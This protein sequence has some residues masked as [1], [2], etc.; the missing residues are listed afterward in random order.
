MLKYID[1]H[2]TDSR[3]WD[4]M[5][6]TFSSGELLPLW[7]ADMDFETMPAVKDALKDFVDAAPFGYYYPREEYFEAIMDWEETHHGHKIDRNSICFAPS[8]VAAFNWILLMA[9]RPGDSVILLTPIYGP[10]KKAIVNNDRKFVEC[11]LI[12][13]GDTYEIDFD[14]FEAK[15]KNNN[16][17]LFILCS[18]HNPVGR[19]WR[20]AELVKLMEICRRYNVLVISDE[21][22]HDFCFGIHKHTPT[23]CC[24]NYKNFVITLTSASKTFN[25]AGCKN[26]IVIIED[27]KLRAMY[28]DFTTRIAISDGSSFGYVAVEAAYKNGA[29][30]LGDVKDVIW[31][32]YN[33]VKDAFAESLPKVV[34]GKLEGTYLLWIDFSAYFESEES[35]KYFME[36]VCGLAF[37]YGS[38]FGTGYDCF[39]RM[40]LA[41]SRENV[42]MATAQIIAELQ[43]IGL[44]GYQDNAN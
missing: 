30:W 15:I 14:D 21:I 23:V 16:V 18:P 43:K 34:V 37:D 5:D 2:N 22:H 9:T 19:V 41:T 6:A 7:V 28:K 42:E 11:P 33:L 44:Y 8:V 20:E 26:A 25:L 24:G 1:R 27:E 36:N 31:E 40:N 39:I 10:M 38:W 32:N 12:H 13:K 3:K 29:D 4:G 17:K 35:L